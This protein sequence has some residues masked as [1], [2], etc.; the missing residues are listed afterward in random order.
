[1]REAKRSMKMNGNMQLLRLGGGG[2][3]LESPRD[4]EH[5][6]LTGFN[7]D[8]LS[9]NVQRWGGEISRATSSR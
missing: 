4:Q 6:R 2:K 7:G 1:M 9:L 8:D 5:E 3:A